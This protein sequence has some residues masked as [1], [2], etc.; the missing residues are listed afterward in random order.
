MAEVTFEITRQLGVLS[1]KS[2]GWQKEVNLVIWNGRDE[3]LDIR[4]WNE[5]HTKMGKG[6]TFTWEEMCELSKAIA[7]LIREQG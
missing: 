4:D 6:L 3:K 1:R 2:N 5:D 7:I